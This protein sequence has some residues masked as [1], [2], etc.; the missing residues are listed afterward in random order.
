M[1]DCNIDQEMLK[2]I[3]VLKLFIGL[4]SD[5]DIRKCVKFNDV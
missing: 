4:N 5:T 1:Y 2:L 3:K